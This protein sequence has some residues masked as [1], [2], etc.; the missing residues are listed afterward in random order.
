MKIALKL[1]PREEHMI[2]QD[3][4]LCPSILTNVPNHFGLNYFMKITY[5]TFT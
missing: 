4:T 1:S 2:F 3:L 5:T